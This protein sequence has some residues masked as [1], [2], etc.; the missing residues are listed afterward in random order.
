MKQADYWRDRFTQLED[1]Q[2]SKALD[3]YSTLEDEFSRAARNV[4]KELAAWYTRFAKNENISYEEAKQ[5]LTKGEL[6]AFKM[7]VED[8]IKKGKTLNYSDQWAKELERASA[9]LHVTRLEAMQ[10]QMQ[11]QVEVMYGYELDTFDR[12]ISSQYKAGYYKTMFEFQKGF[13]VGFDVMKL[14]D[15]KIA[16][17]I[18][19]PWAPDGQNFS[20]RIWRDKNKLM[21]EMPSILTQATI[22]GDGYA[23]TTKLLADRFNVSK[24]QAKNLVITESGFFSSVSQADCFNDLDVKQYEIVATLDGLTSPICR[25]MDGKVFDMKDRKIG[26]TAPI[27]HNRCRSTTCPA[28]NDEFELNTKRAARDPDTGKTYQIPANMKYSDWEKS[29]IDGGS[30]DGLDVLNGGIIKVSNPFQPAASVKDAEEYARNELGVKNVSYKGVDVETANAWNQG[31]AESFERFPEL[32]NNYGFVGEARER[33]KALKPVYKEDYLDKLI[34]ANPNHT[35]PQLEPYAD[36]EIKRFMRKMQVS[37]NTYAQSW[38]PQVAPLSD[39]KG[40]AVNGDWGKKSD[41]FVKALENDVST[42]YH[43]VGCDT[44]RSVL[45]HEIGHQLDNLLGI[46]NLPDVQKIYN[47]RSHTEITEALSKYSWNN[48]NPNKYSEMVAEAWAEYCNNPDPRE[49][50]K[51]IGEMIED[52]YKN[53]FGN[54]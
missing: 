20:S 3:Y 50:A 2:N 25:M 38:S 40:V 36:K 54:P 12:F 19:K 10:L 22:R 26:V 32:K 43:P 13:G 52:A 18:A 11:Q 16:K 6:S 23:K 46:S 51:T 14:D 41:L 27:F 33:N 35:L 1:A 48:K 15:N 28:F 53:K 8:Y 34:K 45:D 30:K 31:L 29:F 47:S 39:F 42:K 9:K 5:V 37:K 4:D 7:S 17:L 24:S 49:I 44:I 21:T